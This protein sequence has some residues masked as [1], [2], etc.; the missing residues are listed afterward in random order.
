LNA[1]YLILQLKYVFSSL[2]AKGLMR[3]FEGKEIDNAI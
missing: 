3:T 1:T 2:L